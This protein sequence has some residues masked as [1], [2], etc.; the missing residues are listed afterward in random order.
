MNIGQVLEAHLGYAAKALGW[1]IATPVLTVPADGHYRNTQKL[2]CHQTEKQFYMMEE[3]VN[4]LT[5]R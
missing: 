5:M 1:H 4:L 3:Q 2:N